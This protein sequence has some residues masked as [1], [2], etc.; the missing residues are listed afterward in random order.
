MENSERAA[1]GLQSVKD[2]WLNCTA[3]L[4][5]AVDISNHSIS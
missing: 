3:A 5:K 1:S 2:I 4:S